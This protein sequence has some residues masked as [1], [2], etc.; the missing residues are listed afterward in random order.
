MSVASS[1][2]GWCATQHSVNVLVPLLGVLVDVGTDVSWIA[3]WVEGTHGC[4]Q[5]CHHSH[6][7]GVM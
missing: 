2:N 3:L 1:G 7:V 4:N 6:G 5:C